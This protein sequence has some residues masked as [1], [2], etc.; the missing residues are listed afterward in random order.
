LDCSC[1]KFIEIQAATFSVNGL[2]DKKRDDLRFEVQIRNQIM[3][4][5]RGPWNILFSKCS[6]FYAVQFYPF[7]W[8]FVQWIG[9][10]TGY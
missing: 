2:V 4:I 6:S 10:W 5:L 7:F 3:V 8:C 1:I 9:P